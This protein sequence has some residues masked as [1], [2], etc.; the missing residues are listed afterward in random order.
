MAF[1]KDCLWGGATAANQYERCYPSGAKGVSAVDAMTGGSKEHS[2]M[3]SC[4]TKDG[5]TH[6]VTREQSLP[7]GAVGYVDPEQYYPRHVATDFYHHWQE[8]IALFAE[9][10]FK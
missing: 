8:V 5:K 4:K 7:A 6:Q 2:R 10:G 9:R 1:P 3:M